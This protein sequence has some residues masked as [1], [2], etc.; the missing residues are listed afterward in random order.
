VIYTPDANFVGRDT[1]TYTANDGTTTST[2]ATVTLGVGGVDVTPAAITRVRV[3][4]RTW[5]RGRKLPQASAR[6]GTRI[7]WRLSEAAR[8]TLV[9]QRKRG[10]RFR[11]AGT[12]RFP[13]AHPGL[14]AVRFQGRLNRRKRLKLGTYRVVIGA[15]DAAGNRS[16]QRRSKTFRIVRR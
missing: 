13:N 6:T 3:F 1:F 7:S 15:T 8:V 5:K 9:F 16:V 4:P 2:A 12:L 14:N 10:T 11:R